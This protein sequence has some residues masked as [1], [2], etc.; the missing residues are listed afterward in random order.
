MSSSSAR[1]CERAQIH[2]QTMADTV[3]GV[4]RERQSQP[5][6]MGAMGAA[7]RIVALRVG[8]LN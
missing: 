5:Y 7:F 1:L 8:T 6:S 3:K 4:F 2:F